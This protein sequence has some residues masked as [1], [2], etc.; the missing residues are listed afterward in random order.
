MKKYRCITC[1]YIYDPKVGD[2]DMF[3]AGAIDT[4]HR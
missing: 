2:P 4:P 3:T 1:G